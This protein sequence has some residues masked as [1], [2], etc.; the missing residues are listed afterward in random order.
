[1]TLQNEP[2]VPC[3]RDETGLKAEEV[4][5]L[6]PAVPGWTLV[7]R[8][9]VSQLELIHSCKDFRAALTLAN[10]VGELAE[11]EDHHPELTVEWGRL[12]IR[13]WT[14]ILRGLHR[15]DFILAAR[16]SQLLETA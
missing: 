10:C 3:R 15:N 7:Q 8:D 5:R 2:C 14:H 9:G 12:T 11:A 1:M 13:Y 6:L 16:T 4:Q